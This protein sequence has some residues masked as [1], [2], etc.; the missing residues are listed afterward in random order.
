MFATKVSILGL[1]KVK[2]ASALGEKT[3]LKK[4]VHSMDLMFGWLLLAVHTTDLGFVMHCFHEVT[5]L[6]NI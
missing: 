1:Y 5:C 6:F 4:P 3:F 2:K